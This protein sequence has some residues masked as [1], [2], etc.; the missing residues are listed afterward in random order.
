[1]KQYYLHDG[2]NQLGPFSPDELKEKSINM[3]T[4]VWKEGMTDWVKAKEIP[5]LSALLINTPPPFKAFS[6][7]PVP[8]AVVVDKVKYSQTYKTGNWIGRNPKLSFLILALIC[9]AGYSIYNSRNSGNNT[10]SLFNTVTEKTPEQLRMELQLQEKQNP[11]NYLKPDIT[12]R[13]NL[14][15]ERVFEGNIS[16]TASTAT[17]KDIVLEVSYLSKTESVISKEKF[18]IYEVIGPQKTISIKK[19][20]T[21]VPSAT[22]GFSLEVVSA[23]PVD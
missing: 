7:N 14:I 15:S 21:F 8:P 20:K 1:M 11:A 6:N 2:Q 23:I 9:I 13:K 3:E 12:M 19:I 17:F 16:N 22:E 5:E 10:N 18:V 4:F